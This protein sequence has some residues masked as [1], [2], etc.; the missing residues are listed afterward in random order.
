MPR[1]D[2][3][4]EGEEILSRDDITAAL[5]TSEARS[6]MPTSVFRN[7]SKSQ[8]TSLS[9]ESRVVPVPGVI[10]EKFP[11]SSMITVEPCGEENGG[12]SQPMKFSQALT[13][14][15]ENAVITQQLK[16]VLS[17]AAPA[18]L[19]Q[20]QAA[21]AQIARDLQGKKKEN[22]HRE[23]RKKQNQRKGRKHKNRKK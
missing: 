13:I 3:E 16:Q 12:I 20:T 21:Q 22:K 18:L 15:E 5:K 10:A 1:R 7:L 8:S 14:S 17:T 4:V 2:D 9:K 23:A 6:F 11:E 19:Q